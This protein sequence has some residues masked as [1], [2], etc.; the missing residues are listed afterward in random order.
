METKDLAVF[1][2]DQESYRTGI[3]LNKILFIELLETFLMNG[4]D[5]FKRD[6]PDSI[7]GFI[8]ISKNTSPCNGAWQVKQIFAAQKGMGNIIYDLGY[9]MSPTGQLTPDRNNLT[10]YAIDAW[11]GASQKLSSKLLDDI[12]NPTNSDPNDDCEIWISD[13][14]G[15][16]L[17]YNNREDAKL[18]PK[19]ADAVNK[20]YKKSPAFKWNEIQAKSM[21]LIR[22]II[23]D[24]QDEQAIISHLFEVGEAVF[25]EKFMREI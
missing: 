15:S 2:R 4:Q 13:V 12:N 8:T 6:V 1:V 11:V 24:P 9:W 18:P 10:R 3:V 21:R 19:A 14:N 20:S 25:Y 17:D 5:D 7:I 22:S 23:T 16:I